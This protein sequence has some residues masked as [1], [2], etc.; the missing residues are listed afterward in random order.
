M[1]I[2]GGSDHARRVVCAQRLGLFDVHGNVWEWVEDCWN[3]GYRGAPSD[4]SAR[5]VTGC[6]RRVLRG[7]SWT[8]D[9]TGRPGGLAPGIRCRVQGLLH[10][11]PGSSYTISLNS[12]RSALPPRTMSMTRRRCRERTRLAGVSPARSRGA[13]VCYCRSMYRRC[14]CDAWRATVEE[15]LD[16]PLV[17]FPSHKV[18]VT[19]KVET[20][21]LSNVTFEI[22]WGEY[23]AV[24]GPS[25]CG[26]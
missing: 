4:G 1:R 9:P 22:G 11:L 15:T 26:K 2:R 7:G 21:R 3:P 13:H 10:R 17:R 19:D 8:N 12:C 18:F 25:R 23:L 16:K 14:P 5:L 6:T 20:H 24:Q